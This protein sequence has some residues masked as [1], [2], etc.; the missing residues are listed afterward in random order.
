MKVKGAI[1]TVL[2]VVMVA[3]LSGCWNQRELNKIAIVMA[4]GVDKV[5]QTDNYRV[6]FQVVNPGA[7]AS[8]LTGGGAG[9]MPVTV[10]TST[11]RTLLEAIR[12]SSQRVP[13]ELFFSHMQLLVIGEDLA[14]SGVTELFD[15]F[16][17]GHEV[18]L[19]TKVIVTRGTKAESILKILT[20]IE[21][22]PANGLAGE[23]DMS[24]KL[25]SENINNTI[26]DVIKTF[27][28]EGKNPI[29]S[30]AAIIGNTKEGYKKTEQSSPP[31]LMET[32]GVAIF[33]DGKLSRWVDGHAARGILLV[34]NKVK[35]TLVV[36]KPTGNKE[37][38]IE[39]LRSLT[40]VST[41]IKAGIPLIHIRIRQEGRLGGITYPLDLSKSKELVKLQKEW[42]KVTNKEVK[43]AVKVAQSAKSDIFGIGEGMKRSN[44]KE[45]EGLK[46]EWN[47]TFAKAK[48]Y[49]TVD[50]IIRRTGMRTKPYLSDL[51]E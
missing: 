5:E 49:V 24:E 2:L 37:V 16:D 38:D 13:R 18:R 50:S 9:E 39:I 15:Y 3:L 8:G 1:L 48:V 31:T 12:K 34:Q 28:T 26:D 40:D 27:V 20:P 19:T 51:E 11:G 4:M 32:R 25:W 42:S 33:K 46:K 6:S 10:F 29:I 21:K 23:M 45:W 44:P 47:E 36:L 14:K 41:E 43:E 7:V 35:S 17:R 30:G 22:I